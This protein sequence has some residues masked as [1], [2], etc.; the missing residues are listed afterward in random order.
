MKSYN[1]S[2]NI[3]CFGNKGSST[4]D[5]IWPTANNGSLSTEN[6]Q[7]LTS[8]SNSEKGNSNSGTINGI[9]FAIT[10]KSTTENRKV[11]GKMK[12][13]INKKWIDISPTR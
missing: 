7:L 1:K 5:H 12:I 2:T 4:K 13:F 8:T 10:A 11:I 3:D 6:I 9:K